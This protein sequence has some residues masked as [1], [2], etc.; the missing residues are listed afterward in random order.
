LNLLLLG[1][2][3]NGKSATANTIL[4]FKAFDSTSSTTSVTSNVQSQRATFNDHVIQVV[5]IPG[6]ADTRSKADDAMGIVSGNLALALQQSPEGFH[7]VL[8]VQRYGTRFTEE[9]SASVAL[10][11]KALGERFVREFC[12]L[13]FTCG[14]LFEMDPEESGKCFKDRCSEQVGELSQLMQDCGDRVVLFDNRDKRKQGTK[15]NELISLIGELQC[16][17]YTGIDFDDAK[18]S[19]ERYIV[20]LNMPS[21]REN[22]NTEILKINQ[23]IASISTSPL[24]ERLQDLKVLL[25]TAQSLASSVDQQDKG[26]GALSEIKKSVEAVHQRIHAD[27]QAVQRQMEE[28]ERI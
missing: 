22:T 18:N 3:G 1:K 11:K 25:S 8:L 2:T 28:E 14:D 17:R 12:I 24:H 7:A 23:R 27:M 26:T 9:D 20:E 13:V 6:L 19:R 4:G 21:I 10:L 16:I 5:E 15:L